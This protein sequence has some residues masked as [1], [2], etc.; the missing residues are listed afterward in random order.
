MIAI[1]NFVPKIL[2]KFINKIPVPKILTKIV[3]KNYLPTILTNFVPSISVP[4]IRTE[5]ITKILVPKIRTDIV[6]KYTSLYKRWWQFWRWSVWVL[7]LRNRWTSSRP[8][9]RSFVDQVRIG[10]LL[11]ST[12]DGLAFRAAGGLLYTWY[13]SVWNEWQML[14]LETKSFTSALILGQNSNSLALLKHPFIPI[15]ERC[16]SFSIIHWC[17]ARVERLSVRPERPARF[18]N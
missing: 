2:T 16:I 14:H 5:I 4:K 13:C 17:V 8:V 12:T 7:V 10:Q 18:V 1:K 11:L 15:C 9:L 3:M 6:T